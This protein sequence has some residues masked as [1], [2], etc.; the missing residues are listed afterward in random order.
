ML[1]K[2]MRGPYWLALFTHAVTGLLAFGAY[3]AASFPITAGVLMAPVSTLYH[4]ILSL[5]P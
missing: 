2:Q 1:D 4:Y 3:R 5:T